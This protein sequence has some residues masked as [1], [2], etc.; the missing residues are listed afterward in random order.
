MVSTSGLPN[1]VLTGKLRGINPR[2]MNTN[3]SVKSPEDIPIRFAE[4]W[5]ERN[6][7]NIAALFDED[8][9]FV[10]VVGIWWNNRDD[11]RKAHDYGLKVIFSESDLKVTKTTVKYLTDEIAIVHTRMRLK[12][13]SSRESKKPETRFNLFTFIV[14]NKE[15][16]WSCAAAHNTDIIPGKETNVV[17]DGEIKPV[18]YRE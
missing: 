10:N 16:Q 15:G 14:H 12:G 4:A 7:E 8:A 1:R 13:Q 3:L 17:T 2:D 9:D 11:I 18:D 6:A 5:N